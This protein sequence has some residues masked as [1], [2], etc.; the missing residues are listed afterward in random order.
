MIIISGSDCYNQHGSIG[1]HETYAK[2]NDLDYHFCYRTSKIK[3]SY[4]I[5]I[6]AILEALETHEQVLWIDDDVFFVDFS[7]DCREVQ[8][9]YKEPFIATKDKKRKSSNKNKFQTKPILIN[10]G[11]MFLRKT[12]K[13]VDFLEKSLNLDKQEV[14]RNWDAEKFGRCKGYD[15][16]L[17]VYS[18]MNNYPEIAKLLEPPGYNPRR[19][20]FADRIHPLVHFAGKEKESQINWFEENIKKIRL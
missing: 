8:N 19:V 13:T 16:I 6:Y 18:L 2:K 14:L 12:S 3:S 7:W 9:I 10:S 17:L 4:C 1:N 20:D 11:V 5:K 15:Q